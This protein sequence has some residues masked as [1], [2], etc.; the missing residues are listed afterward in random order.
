MSRERRRQD[1]H[2]DPPRHV[3]GNPLEWSGAFCPTLCECA[4]PIVSSSPRLSS[5]APLGLSPVVVGTAC[6]VVSAVAYAAAHGC[7]CALAKLNPAWVICVKE[8]VTVALVGPWLA[9]MTWRGQIAWPRQRDLVTLVLVALAV[10][11]VGNQGLVWALS[12]IGISIAI[13]A[14]MGMNLLSAALLGW[15]VLRERVTRRTV[16]AIGLL[17]LAVVL[18]KAGAGADCQWVSADPL[19]V[20]LA[21]GTCAL[22]GFVF[23]TMAV[24]IRKSV[25][26]TTPTAVILVLF[27]GVGTLSLGP[28][29]LWQLGPAGI[30]ATE[31]SALGLMLLSGVLNLIGFVSLTKG[32]QF[33]TVVQANVIGASQVAMAAVIGMFFFH[34]T[35]SSSLVVGV[36]LTITGMV[37]IERPS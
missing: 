33:A 10:Q 3:E 16:A 26:G 17:V 37:M 5:P 22:A 25:T 6:C 36:C 7:L 32:L 35:P 29:S 2:H 1:A 30:L 13:P 14:M 19:K 12:M 9:Y 8:T 23:A 31:P 11:L 4:V 28:L 24:A 27:T 20:V 15:L 21:L 34:E 18:L